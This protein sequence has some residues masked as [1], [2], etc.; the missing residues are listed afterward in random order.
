MLRLTLCLALLALPGLPVREAGARQDRIEII[1]T[2]AHPVRSE[3]AGMVSGRSSG[4]R[5]QARGGGGVA[6]SLPDLLAH[7]DRFGI[8]VSI[9]LPPP[10]PT[11]MPGLYGRDELAQL[12]RRSNGRIVFVAGGESINPLLQAT[13]PDAVTPAALQS[14]RDTAEAIIAAGAVGF[15]ELALEH[16]SSGRGDHPYES[17]QPDHPLLLALAGIAADSGLPID[18][19]MEAVPAEMPFPP[20][21]PAAGNPPRLR[22]NI[23]AFERL[24]QH[25]RGAKIVWAHAG[26]DLTG[27]RNAALIRRL[28]QAHSNLY[29]SLKLDD[30]GTPRTAPL[31]DNGGLRPDWLELLRDFPDRFVIGSDQFYDDPLNRLP[32]ARRLVDALPPDLA[33]RIASDNALRLYR[34]RR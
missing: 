34:L 30:H 24:L 12:A 6:N 3:K 33:Q 32:Q 25:E 27:E 18:L 17:L 4:A 10:Y 21:R 1:D 8:A 31:R 23:A 7:M 19:H 9:L 13:P 14:L 26:W 22:E 15:G 29:M 28:L 11:V 20:R 2:H 16:F 5:G